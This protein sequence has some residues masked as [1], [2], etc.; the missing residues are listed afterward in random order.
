MDQGMYL[1]ES[2]TAVVFV[3]I[4]GAEDD[5]VGPGLWAEAWL[6]LRGTEEVEAV[7]IGL[8]DPLQLPKQSTQWTSYSEGQAR[9]RRIRRRPLDE[10]SFEACVVRWSTRTGRTGSSRPCSS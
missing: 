4:G 7:R 10:N 9:G 2:P 1:I 8:A 5:E 6:W 3:A